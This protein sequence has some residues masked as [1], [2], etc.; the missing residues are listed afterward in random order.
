MN[1][2]LWCFAM[3]DVPETFW[4]C[5]IEALLEK[6][7]QQSESRTESGYYMGTTATKYIIKYWNPE[8][9]KKIG[10]C[11]SCKLFEQQ[12]YLQDGRLSPSSRFARG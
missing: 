6:D 9:P 3:E 1:D 4:G 2:Y 11:T 12:S 10:I 5:K 8:N 7:L